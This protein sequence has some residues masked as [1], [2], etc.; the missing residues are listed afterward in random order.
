[1][2]QIRIIDDSLD[3]PCIY[4]A[5]PTGWEAE[6]DRSSSLEAFSSQQIHETSQHLVLQVSDAAEA[7]LFD[8]SRQWKLFSIL[9]S[10]SQPNRGH[11][12]PFFVGRVLFGVIGHSQ[13]GVGGEPVA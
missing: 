12:C 8:E 11:F 7:L 2:Q 9:N 3:A 5:P 13:N 10:T 4:I 6:K 1:M